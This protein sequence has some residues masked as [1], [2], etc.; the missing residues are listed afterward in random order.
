MTL[1]SAGDVADAIAYVRANAGSLGIDKDRLCIAAYSA[2]GP[3]LSPF[4]ARA[5]EYV[6]CVVGFYV[7]MDIRQSEPHRTSETEETLRRFSPIVQIAEGTGRLHA[8]LPGPGREGRDPHPAA[9]RSTASWP[10]RSS[11][12]FR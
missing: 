9:I 5:P 11:A 2:G 10:R 7:F 12:A 3:M 8:R 1:A 6:R 4:L